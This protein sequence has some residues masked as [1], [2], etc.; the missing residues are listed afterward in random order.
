MLVVGNIATQ[1][2][3][4]IWQALCGFQMKQ[5]WNQFASAQIAASAEKTSVQGS[6]IF[7]WPILSCDT[8]YKSDKP[9]RAVWCLSKAFL[10]VS[11][12]VWSDPR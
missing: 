4:V 2:D 5:C 3:Q 9:E 10:R 1:N 6:R 8:T 7:M 12:P 11:F